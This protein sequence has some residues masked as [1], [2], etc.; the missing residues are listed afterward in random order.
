MPVHSAVFVLVFTMLTLTTG[1]VVF[2]VIWSMRIERLISR[3][4]ALILTL[5][6]VLFVGVALI[7]ILTT[8]ETI[9]HH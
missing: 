4:A 3:A 6:T 8:G 2:G 9:Q 7:S 5:V 1:C